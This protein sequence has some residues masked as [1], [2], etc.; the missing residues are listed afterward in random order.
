M[1][2]QLKRADKLHEL[3]Q[4]KDLYLSAF[5]ATERRSFEGLQQQWLNNEA[6]HIFFVTDLKNLLGFCTLWTFHSFAFME[7]MAILAELRGKKIGEAVL[8]QLKERHQTPLLLEVEP[9][10][11]ELSQRRVAF[12]KRN[13]FHLLKKRYIQPSYYEVGK[14]PE[15]RLMISQTHITPKD[16]KGFIDTVKKNVYRNY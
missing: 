4:I 1:E 12:Y 13:G 11:D 9:P 10:T 15:L 8:Y 3:E 14:G 16:L 5:P 6:C 2:V 7:H